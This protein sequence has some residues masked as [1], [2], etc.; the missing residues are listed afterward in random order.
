M[1]TAEQSGDAADGTGRASVRAGRRGLREHLI[2]YT[3][4]GLGLLGVAFGVAFSIRAAL[5]TTTISAPPYVVS[6][7]A[8]I[9]VGWATI[10]LHV[11]MIT[12]QIVLLGR[13]YQP[14]Q[15]LQLPVGIVFGLVIDGALWVLRDVHPGSYAE[16]LA[17]CAVGILVM[18]VGVALEV[19]GDVVMLAG[20]GLIS[21]ICRR[22]DL[23]FGRVKIVNDAA[24]VLAAVVISLIGLGTVA[25]VREGTVAAALL[26]GMIAGPVIRSLR[27]RLDARVA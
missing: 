14:I 23:D 11:V 8:P 12:A 19:V 18:G 2:R 27:P 4:F 13:R 7:I 3:V 21:A 15:L 26:V 16:S 17:L 24:H 25:G 6:L 1:G 22:W 10:I 5:G 9:T 20:E